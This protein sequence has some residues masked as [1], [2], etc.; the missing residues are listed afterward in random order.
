[1]RRDTCGRDRAAQGR[2][3]DGGEAVQAFEKADDDAHGAKRKLADQVVEELTTRTRIDKA[4][5]RNRL[6]Q[7]GE[8]M[9]AARKKAPGE[10][11]AVPSADQ[12]PTHGGCACRDRTTRLPASALPA[13]APPPASGG[14]SGPGRYARSD[15]RST[16]SDSVGGFLVWLFVIT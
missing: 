4:M 16:Q 14:R 9:E 15:G 2:P 12:Y 6:T 1:M 10:P 8:Q 11:L 13:A 3:Q 7:L 5:G